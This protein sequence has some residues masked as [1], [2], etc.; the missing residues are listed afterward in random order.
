[1]RFFRVVGI[2]TVAAVVAASL[3]GIA[4]LGANWE[5]NRAMQTSLD[6]FY[7]PPDPIPSELGTVIRS[8]PLDIEVAG[9]SAQRILYVSERPDG[10]RA[11]SGGMIFIPDAPAPSEGRP[12]VAWEHGT[13]GMGDACVPSRSKNP[14]ADMFTFVGPMMEQ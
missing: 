4:R 5:E 9:G 11:V 8:E 10:T 3:F 12:V 1:M 2:V 7:T 14:T 6:P 13:L